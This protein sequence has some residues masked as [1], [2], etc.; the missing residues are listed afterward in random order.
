MKKILAAV[1]C[2]TIA[3]MGCMAQGSNNGHKNHG[4]KPMTEMPQQHQAQKPV[5]V[6]PHTDHVIDMKVIKDM[7]L[8]EKQLK[9]VAE[10]KQRREEEMKTFFHADNGPRPAKMEKTQHQP[11]KKHQEM[12]QFN[13]KYRK[14]LQK[15]MG[16]KTYIS[17]VEKVNDRLAMH[18][19]KRGMKKGPQMDQHR[20]AE[21]APS[22]M[23][24]VVLTHKRG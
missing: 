13:E 6:K 8:S 23:Q 11:G 22:A 21:A 4:D 16:K 17:Y 18:Q 24:P 1:I 2:M 5:Q 19:D 7:G 14:E 9:K 20:K 12:K 3:T 10:L 15:I